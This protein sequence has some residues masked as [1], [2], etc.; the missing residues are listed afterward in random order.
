MMVAMTQR[1]CVKSSVV[2]RG[3]YGSGLDDAVR[4][5]RDPEH[6]GSQKHERDAT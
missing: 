6:R 4:K 1:C 5:R 2:D 3:R